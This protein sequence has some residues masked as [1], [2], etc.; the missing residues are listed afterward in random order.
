MTAQARAAANPVLSAPILPTLI[1]FAVPNLIA[2]VATASAAIAET[3][4]VGQLGVPA[5]AG[6]ALVFPFVLLQGMFSNGAMGGG[7][8]SAISRALGAGLDERAN[9][10]AVHALW[11]ALCA[12]TFYMLLLLLFGPTLFRWLG[13]NEEAL[14]QAVAYSNVAFLGSIGVWLLNTFSSVIRGSGNML[15][16]ATTTFIVAIAQVLIGGSLGL[17]LGPFP[18]W[19]MPGVAC[20]QV[21]AYFLGSACLYS[22]LRF[23]R[24]RI[25]LRVRSTPFQKELFR[26]ILKVGALAC[27]SPLQSVATML[28]LTALV[29]RF[30]TTAL[31]GFGIGTRLEYL[32]IPISFAIGV[33]SVPMIGMAIGNGNVER[34]RRAAWTAAG[35]S[36]LVLGGLGLLLSTF[37]SL[38]THRFTENEQVIAAASSYFHWAGPFYGLLG[39][40]MCL[41]FSSLGAGKAGGPV[42]AGLL[43]LIIVSVGGWLLLKFQ[44]PVW[45][46]YALAAMAMAGY[47][48]AM[49]VAMRFSH[50]GPATAPDQR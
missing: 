50:W 48:I 37:P 9:A 43:R 4:Y 25:R 34:A 24:L 7:V 12:G 45:T 16:P 5:L 11:I 6:M 35:L 27:V 26:D 20:G 41:Y 42:L 15:V 28:I 30:G 2:M 13:G 22:F 18:R 33:A 8:S 47:G 40:G 44:A 46:I 49:I 3:S 39:M 32:L 21:F 17:G 38:W 36:A 10:L 31:A 23:G 29:A 14:A 19:G 1:R